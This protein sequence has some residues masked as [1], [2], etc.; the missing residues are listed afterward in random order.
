MASKV[1][2]L[3][4]ARLPEIRLPTETPVSADAACEGRGDAG[5]VEVELGVAHGGQSIVEEPPARPLAVRHSS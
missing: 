2:G 3:E 5:V 4:P 1:V